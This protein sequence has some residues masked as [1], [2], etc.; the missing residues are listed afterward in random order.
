MPTSLICCSDPTVSALLGLERVRRYDGGETKWHRLADNADTQ[1][2]LQYMG[3]DEPL[4]PSATPV[5][6]GSQGVLHCV[7]VGRMWVMKGARWRET[8]FGVHAVPLEATPPR[9][10][11]DAIQALRYSRLQDLQ[12]SYL[13]QCDGASRTRT[14][15]A[16]RCPY[17]VH[18]RKRPG[19]PTATCAWPA[20]LCRMFRSHK[21]DC[22][23]SN[24]SNNSSSSKAFGSSSS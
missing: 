18:R 14:A 19:D 3:L 11:V 9:V 15:A 2:F 4:L 8:P 16:T 10:H 20:D 1:H 17:N 22:N 23:S 24:S 6:T 7:A 13:L 12:V 21:R 5:G